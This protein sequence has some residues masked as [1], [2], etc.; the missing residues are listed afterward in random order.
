MPARFSMHPQ[1]ITDT[2]VCPKCGNCG[3]IKWNYVHTHSG[4]KKDL[5]GIAGDFYERLSDKAPY[6]IEIVCG[7]CRVA[8]MAAPIPAQLN[9]IL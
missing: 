4:L 7:P 5:V 9:V 6:P 2:V 3:V 8:V 1:N